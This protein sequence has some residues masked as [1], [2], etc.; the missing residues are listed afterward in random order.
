M[1]SLAP[2]EPP[3]RAH[4][5]IAVLGGLL[6][7]AAGC[8]TDVD[9]PGAPTPSPPRSVGMA[10]PTAPAGPSPLPAPYPD[11]PLTPAV[12]WLVAYHSAS[13]TDGSPAAWIDRVQPYVTDTLNSSD[14]TLRTGS[15]GTDWA[16]Y[17]RDHCTST[18]TDPQAVVP[19]ESPGTNAAANVQVTG[20]VRITC[21]AGA[22]ARPTEQASATL[23]VVKTTTGWRVDQR[24]F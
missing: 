24:L 8:A 4:P 11:S 21:S 17:V 19:A 14:Q 15:G 12:R 22:P 18:V 1:L 20:T 23:V 6:I 7:L 3:H 10:P 9:H 13:W 16:D 5:T 2:P